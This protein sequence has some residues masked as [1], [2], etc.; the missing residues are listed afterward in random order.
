MASNRMRT[1]EARR[2][3][4]EKFSKAE[5]REKDLLKEK[6]KAIAAMVSKTARLRA[7][8]LAKEESDND[9]ADKESAEKP[10]TKKKPTRPAVDK[11]T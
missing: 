8:R 9:A 7:L 5:K 2:R 11:G 3:A 1:E 6:N 4:Q 10:A